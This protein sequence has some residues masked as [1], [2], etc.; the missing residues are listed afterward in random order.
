MVDGTQH[1]SHALR[2][3]RVEVAR[4]MLVQVSGGLAPI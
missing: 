1:I 3:V 2:G 4:H